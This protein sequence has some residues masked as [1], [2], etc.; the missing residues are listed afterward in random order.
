MTRRRAKP[1]R[2]R[3][4]DRPPF[5]P[6]GIPLLG[7][8]SDRLLAAQLGVPFR[9]VTVE[10][11]RRRIEQ[12]PSGR[13]PRDPADNRSE[14]IQIL[15]T[16]EIAARVDAARG[17]L[18]RSDWGAAAIKRALAP[19]PAKL[20]LSPEPCEAHGERYCDCDK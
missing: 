9:A 18:S 20:D 6:A 13:R 8:M 17:D 12:A 16:A 4:G 7:T 3:H 1:A 19:I 5:P 14:R 15:V 11:K 10:R 2:Q